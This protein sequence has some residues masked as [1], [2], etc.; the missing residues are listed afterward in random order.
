M[1]DKR[2]YIVSAVVLAMSFAVMAFVLIQIF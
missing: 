2:I 1:D